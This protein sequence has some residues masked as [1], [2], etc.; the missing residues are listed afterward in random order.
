MSTSVWD[1]NHVPMN[2]Y[3]SAV[4]HIGTFLFPVFV[5]TNFPP[6]FVLDR[7]TSAHIVWFL[8]APLLFLFICRK[9]WN[10]A[11]RNYSSASS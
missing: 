4:R 5:I 3:G 7:L 10:L 9:L 8:A 1:M 6:L 11:I 2:I